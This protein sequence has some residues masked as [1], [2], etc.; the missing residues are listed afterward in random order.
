MSVRVYSVS[1][2][3]CVGSG[4]SPVQGALPTDRRM[5]SSRLILMGDRP[6]A[7]IGREGNKDFPY[8]KSKVKRRYPP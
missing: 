8:V 1:V 5:H 4:L 7:S 2:L 6:E 3:S